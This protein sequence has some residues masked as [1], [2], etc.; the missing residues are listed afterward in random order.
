MLSVVAASI[1]VGINR[2]KLVLAEL[3]VLIFPLLVVTMTEFIGVYFV[4]FSLL[5][6]YVLKTYFKARAVWKR[7]G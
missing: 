4:G 7:F 6:I 3:P 1:L 5:L 2:C